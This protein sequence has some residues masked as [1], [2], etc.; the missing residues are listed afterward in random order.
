MCL[1][2]LEEKFYHLHQSRISFQ[3]KQ[4]L[5]K[6]TN[7]LLVFNPHNKFELCRYWSKL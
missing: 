6:I 1:R 3:L 4:E 7:F 2:R 5:S